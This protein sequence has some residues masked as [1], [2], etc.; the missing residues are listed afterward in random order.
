MIGERGWCTLCEDWYS[1]Q[2]DLFF[3]KHRGICKRHYFEARDLEES[4]KKDKPRRYGAIIMAAPPTPFIELPFI[5]NESPEPPGACKRCG[6]PTKRV[7]M[8]ICKPCISKRAK[9]LYREG[10]EKWAIS[11]KTAP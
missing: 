1:G 11:N 5:V 3:I 7:T 2:N 6:E 4:K 10:M 9:E 8:N